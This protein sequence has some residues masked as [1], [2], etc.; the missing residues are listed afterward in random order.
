MAGVEAGQRLIDPLPSRCP[1][2]HVLKFRHVKAQRIGVRVNDAGL[3]SPRCPKLNIGDGSLA[4]KRN[5]FPIL[6]THHEVGEAKRITSFLRT[7]GIEKV[8]Q[9]VTVDVATRC[10]S[11]AEVFTA[12]P[13][14]EELPVVAD[15]C[16]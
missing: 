1:V 7:H 6:L 2:V 5:G 9:T 4:L 8:A 15:A 3:A 10:H 13:F 12:V 11:E 14:S 16:R